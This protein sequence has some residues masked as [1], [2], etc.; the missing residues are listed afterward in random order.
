MSII[1]RQTSQDNMA[2]YKA[3][4]FRLANI[5]VRVMSGKKCFNK[6]GMFCPHYDNSENVGDEC[7]LR[8]FI[9]KDGERPRECL[10]LTGEDDA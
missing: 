3:N 4:G 7:D 10:A 5:T 2:Y 9:A 8:F 6:N 1:E